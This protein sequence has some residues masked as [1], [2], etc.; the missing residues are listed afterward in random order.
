M[1]KIVNT[2]VLLFIAYPI[3]IGFLTSISLNKEVVNGFQ[4]MPINSEHFTFQN[5]TNIFNDV[6]II[7]S[8]VFTFFLSIISSLI[9]ILSSFIT[10]FFLSRYN[11]LNSIIPKLALFIYSIPSVYYA[12]YWNNSSDS[13]IIISLQYIFSHFNY[14]FPFVLLLTIN[15]FKY[16]PLSFD[17]Q[18]AMDG[19]STRYFI[20][21]IIFPYF[22]PVLLALFLI[23]FVII[24]NDV[25]FST[26]IARS[27]RY[28]FIGHYIIEN[29]YNP[30][31]KHYRYGE[32][33]A[34]GI[35]ISTLLILISSF[36]LL[37]YRNYL[38]KELKNNI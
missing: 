29:I 13:L 2:L 9:I 4:F 16:V 3:I 20:Q 35:I 6:N 19:I 12:T 30:D 22:R 11:Y 38:N 33:S 17:M 14:L 26:F 1:R 36:I 32:I 8:F 37:N 15:Y 25:L 23:V 10:G 34:F 27:E 31:Q 28:R 18:A 24:F 21:K 5:Y 7:Y